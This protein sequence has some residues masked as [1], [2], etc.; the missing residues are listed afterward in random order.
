M[1][2]RMTPVLEAAL[3]FQQAGCSV[4][5]AAADGT[6]A[7]LGAWKRW[8]AEQP[9]EQQLHNWLDGGH[10]GIGVVTGAVSGNLEMLEFEAAALRTGLLAETRDLAQAAGL[11]QT[12]HAITTGYMESTPSGGVHFLYRITGRAVPGNTKLATGPGHKVLAETRGEGGFTVVAPSHGPVH[13]TR[14]PWQHI[15]GA[16]S[17]IP[18][19]AAAARDAIHAIIRTLGEPAT[20]PPGFT[21][22]ARHAAPGDTPRPGDEYNQRTDWADILTPLGWALIAT[23]GD[24]RY[25][26][27]PGKSAGISATTGRGDLDN[28]YVFST[29]TEFRPEVPYTKFGAY[30]VLQ[31]GGDHSAAARALAPPR[32]SPAGSSGQ[33]DATV[34]PP[35]DPMAVA[36]HVT[37]SYDHDGH[38][39]L[40]YWRGTWMEWQQ[41]CW[42]ETENIAVEARARVQLEHATYKDT[43][44]ALKPWQPSNRKIA[45][46]T[47]ALMAITHLPAATDP[48]SWH[49]G[50]GPVP[51]HEIIACANGLLHVGTRKLLAHTPAYFGTTAVPF[52]YDPAAPSPIRWLRFLT[53]LWPDDQDSIDALQEF[54]GY[55]LSG[56]TDL[57]KIM[58]LIGP[59]RSG[60]GTIARILTALIGKGNAAGP[61]LASLGTNF[62]LSPLLGKP[63]AVVSDARLGSGSEHQVVERL[64]SIS[65]EDMITIDR[66]YREPWTGRLPSRFLILSNELPR[67]GDASG[68]IAGRF[69]VLVMT[70]TWLGKENTTLTRELLAELPGILSWA[71]DGLDRI[72][73]TGTMTSPQSSTDAIVAL[74]D[75]VSPVSAFVRDQCRTG[76]GEVAVSD[77]FNAWKAWA[78]ANNFRPGNSATFGR[79]LRA[80][81]PMLR[82][83][84]PRDGTGRER[85]YIGLHL[86]PTGWNGMP[87]PDVADC[88]VCG[89]PMDVVE[90]G[91]TTHPL[92]VPSRATQPELTGGA[93]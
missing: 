36:R 57:H 24:V 90:E 1:A 84:Q 85:H 75:L 77:L 73:A 37:H 41:S 12:W 21:Q 51:A 3:A 46:V 39:T 92:C 67:F 9:G 18:Q 82:V 27:R 2:L 34:P 62:G 70:Q 10:P 38:L 83:A 42:T 68:A 5:P 52:A 55:V 20:P 15:T 22:A 32:P 81:I 54:F 91:Q 11:G 45:D 59:T 53:D 23:R 33:D 4:I 29:S 8:Q 17:S 71:L 16:P 30:A 56:R 43:S 89:Q 66:K 26:R 64:L 76:G 13:P 88:D 31:H 48:P 93:Q 28:L 44:G 35:S 80:V 87:E 50:N 69:I 72:A 60:K 40:R 74:H 78:E 61:T 47:G 7:P 86:R 25:W 49:R 14:K 79:N 6:K 58:L 19:I 63:L 65:G